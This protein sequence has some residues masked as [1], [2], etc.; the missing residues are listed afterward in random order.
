VCGT[1]LCVFGEV[2]VCCV[3]ESFL[4]VWG[5]RVC[6]VWDRFLGVW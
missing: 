4:W 2:N 6:C 3:W 1:V 5:V